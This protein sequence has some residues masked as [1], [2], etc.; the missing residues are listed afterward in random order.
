MLLSKLLEWVIHFGGEPKKIILAEKHIRYCEGCYSDA[1][2]KCVYPCIHDD[3]DT[4][5][6]LKDIADA[7]ALVVATP[8]YWGDADARWYALKEKMTS[9]ENDRWNITDRAGRDPLEGKLFAV[10][11]S[12]LMEGATKAMDD[13]SRVLVQMGMFPVPYG[14]IFQ[15]SLLS[16]KGVQLALKILGEKRFA[17]AEIDIR[18][19]A[20]NLVGLSK[21]LKNANYCFDD[22]A[23][24]EEDW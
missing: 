4:N 2:H 16:K 22:D 6:I 17:H 24:R 11:A 13:I 14:S 5:E 23:M 3:D 10:L 19:A 12:Q 8:V 1:P 15:H 18:L 21:L 7:D 20:R 9:L